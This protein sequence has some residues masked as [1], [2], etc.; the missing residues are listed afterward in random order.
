[1][2]GQAPHRWQVRRGLEAALLL[3][4]AAASLQASQATE[5]PSTARALPAGYTGKEIFDLA[6]ATCHGP[7]G[8]GSP[9]SIVGFDAGVPDFSDC[10]VTTAEPLGDWFAVIHDGGPVRGLDRHMPAFG[11]ALSA[12]DI[13]SVIKYIWTFCTDPAWPRGDLN[14]PRMFF[15]EKAFPENEAVFTTA[16]TAGPSKAVGSEVIYERRFGARNQFEV[17]IPVDVQQ[18]AD[19]EWSRGLGD[20]AVAV[21]RTFYSSLDSGRIFSAGAEMVVPTGK[22]DAGFGSGFTIYEP[23][24][25][26]GLMLPRGM[27]LQA[28]AGIEI[29]SD[30]RRGNNEAYWR[31]GIG[32]TLAQNGGFGRAW[33]PMVEVLWARSTS[34]TAEVDVVPEMQVTLSKLQ[35]VM[36]AGAVRV[37][38]N[39][40]AERHTQVLTYVIWDWFDGGLFDFWK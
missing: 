19:A 29:P 40:R 26:F 28:Q 13:D 10:K 22:E 23:F 14:F 39:E 12:A 21:R 15:I 33:S 27:F 9:R 30:H 1:M 4:A 31:A 25:L 36:V 37:P 2:R 24:A 11:D 6:C 18:N 32:G 35:H 38:I 16:V 17:A 7:D 20:V 5:A 3:W 34:G 8:T